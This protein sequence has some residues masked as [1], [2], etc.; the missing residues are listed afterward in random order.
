[1]EEDLVYWL[2]K[3]IILLCPVTS[4]LPAAEREGKRDWALGQANLPKWHSVNC[5]VCPFFSL[6]AVAYKK[7][8]NHKCMGTCLGGLAKKE[9]EFTNLKKTWLRQLSTFVILFFLS[10]FGT[11]FLLTPPIMHGV[12]DLSCRVSRAKRDRRVHSEGGDRAKRPLFL[13]PS[14]PSLSSVLLTAPPVSHSHGPS[15]HCH[16]HHHQQQQQQQWNAPFRSYGHWTGL[17]LPRLPSGGW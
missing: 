11:P 13:T 10:R 12:S 4:A 9:T 7:G 8:W 16:H 3:D 15:Q 17:L 5:F 1:M 2:S 14:S 6:Q